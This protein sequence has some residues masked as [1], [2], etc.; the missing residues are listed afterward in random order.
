ME[1]RFFA[2]NLNALSH[3]YND[4]EE[5]KR[6]ID[7]NLAR[8]PQQFDKVSGFSNYYILR[9]TDIESGVA[10]MPSF[11]VLFKYSEEEDPNC[12]YLLAIEDV[13]PAPEEE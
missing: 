7:W 9:T 1:T 12:V 3:K 4:I 2:E 11:R 8:N 13:P 6:C 10:P 5:V